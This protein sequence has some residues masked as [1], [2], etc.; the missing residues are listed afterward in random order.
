[1]GYQMLLVPTDYA[2]R[3]EQENHRIDMLLWAAGRGKKFW[4]NTTS[5]TRTTSARKQGMGIYRCLVPCFKNS[6]DA[7]ECWKCTL[8]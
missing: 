6:C 4:S 2:R 8:I 7:V 1:M 5:D 3:R